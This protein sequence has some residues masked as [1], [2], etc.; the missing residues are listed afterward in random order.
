[1]MNDANFTA[2]QIEIA[3]SVIRDA[4]PYRTDRRAMLR[5]RLSA[6]KIKIAASQWDALLEQGREVRG[7]RAG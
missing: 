3:R 4:A 2:E 7:V 6:A 1:M 5:A